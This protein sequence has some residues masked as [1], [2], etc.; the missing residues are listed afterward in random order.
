MKVLAVLL[1][2]LGT[3]VFYQTASG[4]SATVTACGATCNMTA[5]PGG[6]ASCY[7]ENNVAYCYA[8]DGGGNEVHSNIAN[9]SGGGGSGGSGGGS[10]GCIDTLG[11][12]PW[13]L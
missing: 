12:W 2:M 13:L 3:A 4:C 8:Y 5:P 6:S 1:L 9:C 10:S 7:T 11:C